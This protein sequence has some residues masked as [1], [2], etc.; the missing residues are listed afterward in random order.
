MMSHLSVAATLFVAFM[1]VADRPVGAQSSAKP[2]LK[3]MSFN[4]R[5]GSA[6]DGNNRWDLRKE[7]VG[8]TIQTFSPDLLGLQETMPFQA[9]YLKQHL[10]AYNYVGWTRDKDPNGEQCGIMFRAKRFE[11]VKSGQF[12]LSETPETNASKSWD[13]SLPRVATWVVLKDKMNDGKSFLF[14]NT[15]FDHRGKQARLES[16]KLIKS[17]LAENYKEKPIVVTGDFNTGISTKPYSKLVNEQP[18]GLVDSFASFGWDTKNTGTFNGFRGTTSGA[19][20]DWILTSKHLKIKDAA[21]DQT[22]EK[23][24]YPSDHFPVTATIVWKK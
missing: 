1:F 24:R 8:D 14:I 10:E 23:G 18:P 13:S 4:I 20:I 9:E 17:W 5:Y 12:W 6:R 3:V 21:I 15:H 22:N 7:L 16:A 19:R 2:E 11:L